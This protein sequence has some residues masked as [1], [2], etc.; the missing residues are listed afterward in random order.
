MPDGATAA[1]GHSGA[2][3]QGHSGATARPYG[4]VGFVS[5]APWRRCMPAPLSRL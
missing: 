2:G 1:Q 5:T 3:P 4:N